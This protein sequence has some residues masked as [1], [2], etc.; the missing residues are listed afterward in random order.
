MFDI[1]K[2]NQH[3]LIKVLKSYLI[4]MGQ[5]V[6]IFI[7]CKLITILQEQIARIQ[8]RGNSPAFGLLTNFT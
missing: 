6:V 4:R 1:K 3:K 8:T 2:N 7:Y 5:V